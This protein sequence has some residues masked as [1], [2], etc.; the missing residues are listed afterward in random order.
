M[1]HIHL[2]PYPL[3]CVAD[4]TVSVFLLSTYTD[5]VPPESAAWFCQWLREAKDDFRVHKSL[6]SGVHY[7]A[8]G[9]G[10]S[11]YGENYNKAVKDLVDGLE[12]LSATSVYPLGF[13]DQNV[14][15]S[16]HGGTCTYL[17]H[18]YR[19]LYTFINFQWWNFW[20]TET[21][22]HVSQSKI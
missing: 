4:G 10:N 5:G 16:I 12:K 1:L 21:V 20:S 22:V 9:L 14:A 17:L 15:Q 3:Q 13:G 19:Q 2:N 18:V 8:F 11:L 6:L 7:T